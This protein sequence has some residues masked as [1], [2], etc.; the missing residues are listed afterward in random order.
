MCIFLTSCLTILHV[1][2]NDKRDCGKEERKDHSD[3]FCIFL[4]AMTCETYIN[5][6]FNLICNTL[7]MN[8]LTYTTTLTQ[9]L[10]NKTCKNY[11]QNKQEIS[12]N[13][14]CLAIG[15]GTTE[16]IS[17]FQVEIKP[18]TS[19][20]AVGCSVQPPLSYKNSQ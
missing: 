12:V 9:Y 1:R 17:E 11:Q 18:T 20:T 4:C 7:T 16:K 14:G 6:L 19:R 15:E 3:F 2:L 10:R 5:C 13:D 8:V